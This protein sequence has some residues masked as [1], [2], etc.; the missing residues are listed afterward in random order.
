M[1]AKPSLDQLL[2]DVNLERQN[3]PCTNYHL[4]KIALR[5][6]QW[7]TIAPHLRLE[8]ADEE[9]IVTKCPNNVRAQ[10]LE[11]LR[12]WRKKNGDKATYRRLAKVFWKVDRVDLA[13]RV[14]NVLTSECSSSESEGESEQG[15]V[16]GSGSQRWT[17]PMYADYLKGM[18]RTTRPHV[19][20]HKL[21]PPPTRTVFN[22]ALI[23]KETVEF[24]PNEELVRLLQRGQVKEAAESHTEIELSH[25]MR[26]DDEVRKVILIEGAPGSG[27]STLAWHICQEWEKGNLFTEYEVVVFV[28]LRDLELQSATSVADILPVE[29]TD[30]APVIAALLTRSG[31]WGRG[32]LLVLDGWDE[33]QP[34]CPLHSLLMQLIAN[35]T[36][37]NMHFSSLI[38]TS[39][40]V[41]SG[42][43]QCHASSRVEV[44]GFKPKEVEQYFKACFGTDCLN[45]TRFVD[46]LRERPVVYA[47]CFLPLNAVI[48]VHT[49][50]ACNS[51]LP[52]TLHGVFQ[53]LVLSCIMRH[54]TERCS[55]KSDITASHLQD[56]PSD[57]GE[58]LLAL[59]SLAFQGIRVNKAVF[60][61]ED[62][63]VHKCPVDLNTTL[64][65]VQVVESFRTRR[66]CKSYSFFHLQIQELLAAY[67]ISKLEE[68]EQV[69]I[70]KD[71]FGQPRFAAVLQFY[72]A[73]TKLQA[74]G[75]MEV[76]GDMANRWVYSTY[77][78]ILQC[79][80]EAQD[81]SLCKRFWYVSSRKNVETFSLTTH[82]DPLYTIALAYFLCHCCYYYTEDLSVSIYGFVNIRLLLKEI[83]KHQL[84]ITAASPH[85]LT[86]G[87]LKF[88]LE[89]VEVH[90]RE[91]FLQHASELLESLQ[92]F[93]TELVL[94]MK[95]CNE[96]LSINVS[97]YWTS[98]ERAQ[99]FDPVCSVESTN[100]PNCRLVDF[101]CSSKHLL[102]LTAS[103][104]N[105]QVPQL[106]LKAV[107]NALA[108][109]SAIKYLT[110]HYCH[111]NLTD[112]AGPLLYTIPLSN[113]LKVI[114]L[115]CTSLGGCVSPLLMGL[116]SNTSVVEL[117]LEDCKV[118]LTGE[119]GQ[120][121][122]NMLRTN[123]TLRALN[124][125]FNGAVDLQAICV[126]LTSNTS[127]AY[128]DLS[129][130]KLTAT[131]ESGRALT[132]M[133][134]TNT[135]LK[136][137]K[138]DDN[139]GISNE[140][141][142]YLAQGLAQNRGLETLSV[143]RC[144]ISTAVVE[145]AEAL[146]T[147][148]CLLS[149]DMSH[150]V[151]VGE[152]FVHIVR[153][154]QVNSTLRDLRASRCGI[155]HTA[156]VDIVRSSLESLDLSHNPIGDEGAEHI[157]QLVT[158]CRSLYQLNLEG[159]GIG[160]RGV[161][162]LASSLEGN[163]SLEILHI[164]WNRF[165]DTGLLALG[166]SLKRN[167]AL[168]TLTVGV[169]YHTQLYVYAYTGGTQ[170]YT[171]VGQK[172]FVLSLCENEHL[173]Y[174]RLSS[175]SDVR[176]ELNKVNEIRRDKNRNSLSTF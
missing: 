5:I 83:L 79:I 98:L 108:T 73:F 116:A 75:M 87:S 119:N 70:F 49:F 78:T 96:K 54:V 129:E 3:Q 126:A 138:L 124:L 88:T 19:L 159:C 170:L 169:P 136:S 154:L 30:M 128:L 168:K 56:L 117:I 137:L 72:A 20:S 16:G 2:K 150:S 64:S 80:Y 114:D 134:Q 141:A 104:V 24:G 10:S 161:E 146:K 112:P 109:N 110:L 149:L 156:I 106:Y 11:M 4:S 95:D 81:R 118:D 33:L 103:C 145:L 148:K 44:L 7:Q 27:K 77:K 52:H 50:H 48:V 89:P 100:E 13:G 92:L 175:I 144:G 31:W 113:N 155:A 15:C 135:T 133:L 12:K 162:C 62:F 51:S 122:S 111:F 84:Q 121:L 143:V 34:D 40:P 82:S 67:H 174:L 85:C 60:S 39:R 47:S 68:D 6:T 131:A 8:E 65:L 167:K 74:E 139:D 26:A 115:T 166:R 101:I 66:C 120:A 107:C 38:I 151:V 91:T 93:I 45:Y 158:K 152:R 43:L 130:C 37:L 157:A 36:R 140:G 163:T 105:L 171:T 35:P 176:D 57:I 55:T 23:Q 29:S 22:L 172:Q 94:N 41:T 71:L 21:L 14:C 153:S 76:L 59:S 53:E 160:D 18:Y 17:L 123:T 132:D 86:Y 58:P 142:V 28:Q 42:E 9:E 165:T 61:E 99:L 97:T 1:A 147:N 69:R 46:Q 102:S 63:K 127:L 125:S 164:P 32:V 25:L 173:T 90:H